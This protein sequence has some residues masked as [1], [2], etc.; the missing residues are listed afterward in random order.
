MAAFM[1]SEVGR[2][3]MIYGPLRT[4]PFVKML[5]ELAVTRARPDGW[6]E[7]GP[8]V[9]EIKATA[10]EAFEM[11]T[12]WGTKSVTD[13]VTKIGLFDVKEE[14][15]EKGGVRMLYRLKGEGPPESTGPASSPR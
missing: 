10:P 4:T 2:N 7:L 15:S 12:N 6:A 14:P 3:E 1:K 9:G 13:F 11:F 5:G 8:V